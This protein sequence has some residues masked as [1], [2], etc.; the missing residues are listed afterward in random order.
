MRVKIRLDVRKSLKRKKR[1]KRK[2]GSEFV[3]VC[4]YERLGDFC[5]ACGLV[6]HTERFCRRTIDNRGEGGARDWGSWLRAPTRRG[7]GQGGR[8]WLRN[9]GD[10]DWAAKFGGENNYPNFPGE[11]SRGKVNVP[12]DMSIIRSDEGN[13]QTNLAFQNRDGRENIRSGH[14]LFK[15]LSDGLEVEEK[16][17]LEIENSKR[18]RS[19]PESGTIMD[20]ENSLT[21]NKFT[22]GNIS[23]KETKISGTD[24]SATNNSVLVTLALQASR[25]L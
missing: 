1:I 4:K 20:V 13:N 12:T 24:F 8:K 6:T 18:M 17:G 10:V 5:F 15:C 25:P 9:E 19:G 7:A 2:N 16:S 21:R 22:D 23:Q 3:V 11:N 14:N